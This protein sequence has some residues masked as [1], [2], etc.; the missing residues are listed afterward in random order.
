MG[1]RAILGDILQGARC[2]CIPDD[3]RR[4]GPLKAADNALKLKA[5]DRW[6]KVLDNSLLGRTPPLFLAGDA[7]QNEKKR[8]G[9]YF[10]FCSHI[11]A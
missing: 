9:L 3:L 8:G 5:G 2:R 10:I 11:M 7:T 4:N 1:Q 6:A